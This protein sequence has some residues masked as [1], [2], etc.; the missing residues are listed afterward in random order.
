MLLLCVLFFVNEANC[1]FLI[2]I[3]PPPPI[4]VPSKH[5][6]GVNLI[7]NLDRKGFLLMSKVLYFCHINSSLPTDFFCQQAKKISKIKFT[8]KV[9]RKEMLYYKTF[10]S[11]W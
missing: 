6:G 4:E 5:E 2:L 9:V 10:Y 3:L 8:K 7:I 11:T 1:V